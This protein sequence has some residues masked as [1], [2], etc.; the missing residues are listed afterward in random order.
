[1]VG[2]VKLPRPV[3]PAE[4]G[5]RCLGGWIGPDGRFFVAAHWEHERV[6]AR[7]RLMGSGP[8]DPW[9]VSDRWCLVKTSG[10][11]LG[12]LPT[13]AQ[14]DTVGELIQAAPFDCGYRA[15]LREWLRE[16]AGMEMAAGRAGERTR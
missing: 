12:A 5:A 16:V 1:V 2:V 7:L 4:A 15:A 3:S 13:Q 8:R 6:A 10:Q 11:V 9:D 14:L